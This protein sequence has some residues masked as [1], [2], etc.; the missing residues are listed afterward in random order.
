MSVVGHLLLI[1]LALLF[2]A[3]AA[4]ALI[5]F[6]VLVPDLSQL[7]IG[8]VDE[9]TFNVVVAFGTIFLTGYA[10]LPT[11]AVVA[12]AEALAIRSALYYAGCGA[13]IASVLDLRLRGFDTL[14]LTVDGFARRELEVMAA[15]GIVAGFVYWA[16]SGR[17]A[18]GLWARQDKPG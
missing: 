12:A 1:F 2:A 11:L 17:R 3:M 5:V 14:A 13:L 15:A 7:S 8:T 16:I 10:A 18:G 6:A 9:S 4:G